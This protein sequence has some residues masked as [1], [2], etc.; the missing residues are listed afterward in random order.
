[1]SQI[2]AIPVV[3]ALVLCVYWFARI[4]VFLWD[5]VEGCGWEVHPLRLASQTGAVALG[6]AVLAALGWVIHQLFL[7]TQSVLAA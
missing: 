2:A 1:M 4:A 6:L 3:L 5:I 7:L